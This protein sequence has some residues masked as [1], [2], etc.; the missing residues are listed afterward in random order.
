MSD[1]KQRKVNETVELDSSVEDITP[2]RK[3]VIKEEKVTPTK[4]SVAG[5]VRGV[6]PL[7]PVSAP[8]RKP[9]VKGIQVGELNMQR[10][11]VNQEGATVIKKIQRSPLYVRNSLTNVMIQD[12]KVQETYNNFMDAL[13]MM[14]D[15]IKQQ[16]REQEKKKVVEV[17]IVEEE[18]ERDDQERK[19]HRRS[20]K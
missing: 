4:A 12:A 1:R 6:A 13:P 10:L 18:E 14:M 8:V 3:V 7:P 5:N 20:R 11:P 16:K 2:A 15:F 17:E 9:Q 19:K